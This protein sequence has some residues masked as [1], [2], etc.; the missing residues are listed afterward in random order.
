MPHIKLIWLNEDHSIL[1]L[2]E[3]ANQKA[4]SSI[5]SLRRALHSRVRFGMTSCLTL[6]AGLKPF[7]GLRKILLP[8]HGEV[9]ISDARIV[10]PAIRLNAQPDDA[11][12]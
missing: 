9:E 2:K 8:M 11:P 7:H 10:R 3:A 5:D 12:K 6:M 1:G 4:P